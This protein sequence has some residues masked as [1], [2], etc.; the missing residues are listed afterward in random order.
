MYELQINDLFTK[1]PIWILITLLG[2]VLI[3]MIIALV[4]GREVTFW[5]PKIGA[6]PSGELT[7][8]KASEKASVVQEDYGIKILSPSPGDEVDGVVKVHGTFT[9][10]PPVGLIRL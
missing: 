7:T 5:P 3:F 6:K 1:T 9:K 4:T 8:E 2:L 10:L